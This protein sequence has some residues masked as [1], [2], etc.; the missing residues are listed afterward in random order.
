MSSSCVAKHRF[1]SVCQVGS[2]LGYVFACKRVP[3]LDNF[4]LLMYFEILLEPSV[5]SRRFSSE[6]SPTITVASF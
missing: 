4:T 1:A 3:P 5:F 2:A 6:K